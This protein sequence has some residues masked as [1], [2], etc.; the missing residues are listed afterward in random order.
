VPHVRQ[1][2][3]ELQRRLDLR[4][5][6][7]IC[8]RSRLARSARSLAVILRLASTSPFFTWPVR[9]V[10]LVPPPWISEVA[11]PAPEPPDS[12]TASGVWK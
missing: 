2:G 8:S 11:S 10:R 12:A 4:F 6:A 1:L 7:C 3:I 9:S 5:S